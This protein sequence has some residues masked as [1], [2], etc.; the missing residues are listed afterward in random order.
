MQNHRC[1]YWAFKARQHRA[2]IIIIFTQ[3]VAT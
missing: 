2:I 3:A 1:R